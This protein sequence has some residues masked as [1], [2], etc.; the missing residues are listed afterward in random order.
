MFLF[1]V[2]KR[3]NSHNIGRYKY[4]FIVGIVTR[5]MFFVVVKYYKIT[6]IKFR[7]LSSKNEIFLDLG[8][9]V[10]CF[11]LL[12]VY[13]IHEVYTYMVYLRA[14]KSIVY[15]LISYIFHRIIHDQIF[16]TAES[17]KGRVNVIP[18]SQSTS[19]A[20]SQCWLDSQSID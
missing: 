9:S 15:L 13:Y 11:C 14:L 20:D 6:T 1:Y 12:F 18:R 17:G 7:Y 19:T 2:Q 16:I 8:D 5:S 10:C 3:T 4:F